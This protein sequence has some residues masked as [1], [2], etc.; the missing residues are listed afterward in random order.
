MTV[1]WQRRNSYIAWACVV[2]TL[3]LF[4]AGSAL[5]G[6]TPKRLISPSVS[7]QLNG[8]WGRL[9]LLYILAFV[10]VGALIVARRPG[11]RVGWVCCAIGLFTALYTF[12]SGYTTFGSLVNPQLPALGFIQWLSSWEWS[13]PVTLALFFLP[14]LFPDGRPLSPWMWLA[15]AVVIIGFALA[16]A[17]KPIGEFLAISGNIAAIASLVVRYRRA[18]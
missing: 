1:L 2:L 3:A 11:N 17:G 13:L 16:F 12:V 6:A 15:G 14:L 4:I 9:S 8:W 5:I 18:G 7:V 10:V